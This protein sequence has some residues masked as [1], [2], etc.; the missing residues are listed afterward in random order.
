MKNTFNENSKK[1]ITW[2]ENLR[3][4]ATIAVILLHVSAQ[5]TYSFNKLSIIDW[6]A[7]NFYE[8]LTRFAVPTFLALTGYLTLGR[9]YNLYDFLKRRLSR[10]L[11]PFVFWSSIYIFYKLS[12]YY[13]KSGNPLDFNYI[14]DFF[15]KKLMFGA[16]YH[17]WYIYMLIG[18]YLILPMM[19]KW[20]IASTKNEL[21]YF[22]GLCIIGTTIHYYPLNILES[23]VN[24]D[25]F[26]K[27]WG[28][29]VFGYYLVNY[30][31]IEYNFKNSAFLG[32]L[33]MISFFLISL[34]TFY[35]SVKANDF[36]EI[37]D[38]WDLLQM[39]AIVLLF[40]L[41][42]FL[43]IKNR[44]LSL[45]SQYSFG[46]YLIHVLIID[47]LAK[48]GL[49][50]FSFNPYL[51]IPITTLATLITSF[52]VLYLIEKVPYGKYIVK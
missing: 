29:I 47:L 19:N 45:I 24:L 41:H 21:I 7:A 36:V 15:W 50:Y 39:I 6:W 10:I 2:I 26:S 27:Y 12:I 33:F 43:N 20:I 51:S 4:V 11:I 42:P 38:P 9:N 31:K 28:C 46:I 32:L 49:A 14:L 30:G 48:A 25:Y 44:I 22:M 17:M 5:M 16:D 37:F 34:T 1:E 3:A 52:I 35:Y 40:R 13:L 18:V 23:G 8:S